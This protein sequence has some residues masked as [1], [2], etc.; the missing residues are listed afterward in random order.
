MQVADSNGTPLNSSATVTVNV[1]PNQAPTVAANQAFNAVAGSLA[2]AVVGTVTASDPDP[3]QTLSY[4]IVGGNTLDNVFQIDPASGQL[5]VANAAAL[6]ADAPYTLQIQAKDN[7]STPLQSNPTNVAVQVVASNYVPSITGQVFNAI[8]GSPVGTVVG[9]VVAS[10]PDGNPLIYAITAGNTNNTFQIDPN[11]GQ[12]TVANSSQMNISVFPS[13]ALTVQ[14]TD[15]GF[16]H[17]ANSATV[18]ITLTH[19]TASTITANQTFSVSHNSPVG[20]SFGVVSANDVDN[21]QAVTYSIVA[22]NTNNTFQIDP[23]TGN[24]TVANTTDLTTANSPFTLT[25]KVTDDDP[26][27]LSASAPSTVTVT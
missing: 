6:S 12:I 4:A 19:N 1:T 14:V 11:T 18:T 21:N 7:D 22:G 13:F 23:A 26:R 20:F 5:T 9:T 27:P 3:G 10:N 8:D 15:S 2:G 16:P 24:L 25:I 17:P